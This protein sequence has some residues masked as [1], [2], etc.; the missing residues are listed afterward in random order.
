[1]KLLANIMQ[2]SLFLFD[3]IFVKTNFNYEKTLFIGCYTNRISI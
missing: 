3:C 2:V 1:M